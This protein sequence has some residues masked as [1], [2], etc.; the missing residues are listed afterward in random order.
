[1]LRP[2][3]HILLGVEHVLRRV[4]QV[5]P[6]PES[7]ALILWECELSSPLRHWE[8]GRGLTGWGAFK[9]SVRVQ[10]NKE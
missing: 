4:K 7:D 3:R 1:M 10:G 9:D 8:V 6:T 5:T 2:S